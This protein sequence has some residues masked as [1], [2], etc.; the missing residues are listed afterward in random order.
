MIA[1]NL[2][3]TLTTQEYAWG[4]DSYLAVASDSDN[5]GYVFQVSH[6]QG[7]IFEITQRDGSWRHNKIDDVGTAD[8]Y[9]PRF[10]AFIV[11]HIKKDPAWSGAAYAELIAGTITA[12][13]QAAQLF[14]ASFKGDMAKV[15][16]IVDAGL[17]VNV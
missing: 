4:A 16:K 8:L 2:T 10:R 9:S 12:Y 5:R 11:E 1:R 15:K 14:D 7:D 3:L 17:D 13:V 6:E